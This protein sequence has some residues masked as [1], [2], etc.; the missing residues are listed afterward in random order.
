MIHIIM[1]STVAVIHKIKH[2]ESRIQPPVWE[3]LPGI[4]RPEDISV[5]AGIPLLVTDT[6]VLDRGIQLWNFLEEQAK[7]V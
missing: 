5:K 1:G 7:K 2:M 4:H 6:T 3:T